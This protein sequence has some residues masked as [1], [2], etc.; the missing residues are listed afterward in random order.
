MTLLLLGGT[1]DG[2]QLAQRL[3][4]QHCAVIYSV[5]GLLRRPQLDCPVVSGGFT[6]FGGLEVFVKQRDISAILDVTHPYAQRMSCQA[7]AVAHRCGLPYW[8][9]HR[10]AWVPQ[11]GDLWHSVQHWQA[12]L[13][14]LA[15]KKS[16]L[17]SAG[18]L[19]Q[20]FIDALA[21]YASAGQ[22]QLLRT[23]APPRAQLP[24][25]MQWCK[26]IGPFYYEDEL[27]LMQQHSID[28]LLSKNSGGEATAA[29]LQAARDLAMPVI[30]LER[31]LLPTA[32]QL[33]VTATA[34]AD[35][36]LKHQ[37]T[38]SVNAPISSK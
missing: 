24:A 20:I 32:D 28:M 26:A 18:Q 38:V 19:S 10:P 29:K 11:A 6:Q 14:L 8:R 22:R 7:R 35:F 36:V 33:F 37:S 23:A 15:N 16:L 13:P 25:T 2:R 21:V 9:F 4:R 12:A 1:A 5:A 3:H 27:A 31:P 17:L 34:C 30:M